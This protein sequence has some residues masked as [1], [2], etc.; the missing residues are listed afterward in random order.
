MESN[1]G[2]YAQPGIDKGCVLRDRGNRLH[3]RH[4]DE[5]CQE[6]WLQRTSLI[7]LTGEADDRLRDVTDSVDVLLPVFQVGLQGLHG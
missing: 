2:Q 1:P 3:Y 4:I 6:A 7:P 5:R